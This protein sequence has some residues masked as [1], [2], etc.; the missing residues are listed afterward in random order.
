[1]ADEVDN[2]QL[3]SLIVIAD[4]DSNIKTLMETILTSGCAAVGHEYNIVEI[5]TVKLEEAE[6]G[7]YL[8][9]IV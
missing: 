2:I 6:A 1:M 3:L 7:Y 5:A 8:T 9:Q 4:T